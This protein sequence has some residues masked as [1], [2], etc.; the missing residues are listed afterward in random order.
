MKKLYINDLKSGDLVN[1]YF[2]I[3]EKHISKKKDGNSFL[4]I[5]LSDKSGT[6]K[7]VMWDNADETN[8]KTEKGSPYKVS[9]TVSEYRN[10]LQFIINKIEKTDPED[11]D[12]S[13]FLPS[14]KHNT[15]DMFDR[16][17]NILQSVN[18]PNLKLLLNSF[19]TDKVFIKSFKLAPAAKHMHHAYLGGLLEHSLS[20]AM[21]ADKIATHYKGINRDLLI[22]GAILHDIGK[23]TEFEYTTNI[24]Y[25]DKGR[26]FGHII[27]GVEMISDKISNIKSFPDELEKLLKHMIISHHGLREFGSP[28]TPKSLEAVLLNMV[29][30][31]DAKIT[32]IRQFVDNHKEDGSSWTPYHRP[33]ERFFYKGRHNL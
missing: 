31:I 8:L 18:E 13:D 10:S 7:A 16:L 9:G 15:D 20:T 27:L 26:L 17:L 5:T 11:I 22:T 25:S 24:D 6:I 23:I 29:D 21:L 2:I 4:N 30:D 33:L 19:F 1:N 14:T 28:E 12:Y 32:G 3:A